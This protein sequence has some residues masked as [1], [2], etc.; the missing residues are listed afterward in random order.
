M[1][2]LDFGFECQYTNHTQGNAFFAFERYKNPEGNG[3]P[4]CPSL[5]VT[6]DTSPPLKLG[7]WLKYHCKA[8]KGQ[9]RSK[10]SGEDI[11]C[12]EELGV[13]WENPYTR[14]H[15][16]FCTRITY[17]GNRS[18]GCSGVARRYALSNQKTAEDRS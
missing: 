6:E 18:S 14:C 4:N 13:W 12:L 8:K 3:D 7:S 15:F 17:N 5:H 11:R 2:W 10:I 16:L 1:L 9:G